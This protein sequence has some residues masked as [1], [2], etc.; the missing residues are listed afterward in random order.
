MLRSSRRHATPS[1]AISWP[2][3][4]KADVDLFAVGARPV[5]PARS[6]A[7]RRNRSAVFQDVGRNDRRDI[8][9]GHFLER[10][11]AVAAAGVLEIL[12]RRQRVPARG[13][14]RAA[15]RGSPNPPSGSSARPPRV[16]GRGSAASDPP[17]GRSGRARHPPARSRGRGSRSRR[18]EATGPATRASRRRGNGVDG[19]GFSHHIVR[20]P[21]PR[22]P[23]RDGVSSQ[24]QRSRRSTARHAWAGPTCVA[25]LRGLRRNTDSADCLR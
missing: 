21:Q 15:L 13:P 3:P 1:R 6:R 8:G 11:V 25:T 12:R 4:G 24:R 17:A 18:G 23:Y 7:H 2:N 20:I 5:H 16:R 10:P 19:D 14:R 22:C 9:G